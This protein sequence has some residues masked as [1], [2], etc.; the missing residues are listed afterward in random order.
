MNKTLGFVLQRYDWAEHGSILIVFSKEHGKLKLAD[1][2]LRR[3]EVVGGQADLYSLVELQF[4][5]YPDQ[6]IAY[7]FG[8]ES[9]EKY[10][11]LYRSPIIP[12][13]VSL[14]FEAIDG[15]IPVGEAIPEL[16]Y[17]IESFMSHLEDDELSL[18]VRVVAVFA[19]LLQTLGQVPSIDQC[20]MCQIDLL[21]TN[22]NA[23]MVSE[24]SGLICSVC[25]KHEDKVFEVKQEIILVTKELMQMKQVTSDKLSAVGLKQVLDILCLIVQEVMGRDFKSYNYSKQFNLVSLEAWA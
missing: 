13:Y 1:R 22:R 4:V 23:Y 3:K 6:E 12:I 11:Q 15:C 19:S 8:I 20:V 9:V 7:V 14:V 18:C 25:C 21:N 5:Q 2:S 24:V 10:P 17:L 16:F